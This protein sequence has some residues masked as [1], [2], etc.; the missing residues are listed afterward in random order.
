MPTSSSGGPTRSAAVSIQSGEPRA[1]IVYR[2]EDVSTYDRDLANRGV[3]SR[4]SGVAA[5]LVLAGGGAR[6]EYEAGALSVL[7]PAL[8]HRGER[9]SILVST[10]AGAINVAFLAGTHASGSEEA[11]PRLLARWGAVSK[12]RSCGPILTRQVPLTVLR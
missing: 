12:G 3:V 7:L 8:S 9:P 10:S 2:R 4:A 1:E 5:G 11:A 6:G